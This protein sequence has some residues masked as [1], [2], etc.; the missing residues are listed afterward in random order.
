MIK[1]TY[2]IALIFVVSF[3]LNLPYLSFAQTA[4]SPTSEEKIIKKIQE[5]IKKTKDRLQ[6]IDRYGSWS[7]EKTTEFYQKTRLTFNRMLT[8]GQICDINRDIQKLNECD[9]QTKRLYDAA[10]AGY[11]LTK[12]YAILSG[13]PNTCVM[14]NLGTKPNREGTPLEPDKTAFGD[15]AQSLYF[16]SGPDN[17]PI[18]ND[19]RWRVEAK[20]GGMIK[21]KEAYRSDPKDL[22]GLQNRDNEVNA[23]KL[24]QEVIDETK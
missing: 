9:S 21:I 13:K 22:A 2:I 24:V 4:P 16:C 8:I 6:Y 10:K 5:R 12:Y 20:D 3:A 14:A 18:N 23:A 1:P 11:R 7:D 17:S 19:F 15:R